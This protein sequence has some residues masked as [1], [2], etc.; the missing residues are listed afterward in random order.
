MTNKGVLF[1]LVVFVAAI[2]AIV[3]SYCNTVPWYL[4]AALYALTGIALKFVIA[5]FNLHTGHA[6]FDI[7]SVIFVTM[8]S[9]TQNH[10]S[11]K[12]KLGLLLAVAALGLMY[13][14]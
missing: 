3:I 4:F 1:T 14:D 12:D 7:L 11:N 2:E 13:A 8:I 10:I 9:A 5:T 6:M